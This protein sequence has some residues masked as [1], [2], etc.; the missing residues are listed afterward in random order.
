VKKL[1]SATW[2]LLFAVRVLAGAWGSGSF[3]ND[4]A[5]DWAK[6]FEEKPTM[7]FVVASLKRVTGDGYIEAPEAS[8][9]IAAAEV[10]AA[11]AGKPSPTL[12]TGVAAWAAKQ[13]RSDATAQ[14]PLARQAV[15][16]VARGERSE[17]RD[18]W[19][20]SNAGAWQAAISD[21]ENR[22]GK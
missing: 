19:Q 20:E 12:P 13:S 17:L 15:A 3:E 21:L 14:L 5:L 2:I 8:A 22:L 11:A 10:V 4:D 9:A 7:A 16:R 6:E 1:L 18:L